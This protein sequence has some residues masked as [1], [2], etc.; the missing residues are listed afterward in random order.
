[1]TRRWLD[2][3]ALWPAILLA[4]GCAGPT[5][6]SSAPEIRIE[7]E[8]LNHAV[9]IDAG[10]SMVLSTPQRML[11]ISEQSLYSVKE[12]DAHGHVIDQHDSYQS[13]PWAARPVEVIAGDFVATLHTDVEGSVRLNLLAE[14]FLELD[15]EQL[16]VVQIAAQSSNGTRG[17]LNLLVSRELRARLQ[18][19][20]G[21]IYEDLED[22]DVNRW[23]Y[24]VQRLAELGLDEESNQLEN[25][26]ILLTTGD[27]E[28]QGDFIQALGP[29]GGR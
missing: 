15:F 13:L 11:R 16:R 4:A 26:L 27:P 5:Q 25:M 6:Q 2:I 7:R 29:L 9:H 10:E 23:A 14:E 24:R 3:L 18:E 22:D 20:V 21:L 12:L 17:E 8:L 1:M 28:L 19:A